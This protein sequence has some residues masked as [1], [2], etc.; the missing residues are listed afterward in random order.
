MM[1]AIPS[2]GTLRP[3]PPVGTRGG[4]GWMRGPCACPGWGGLA[5]HILE[6]D[7]ITAR[8]GQAQGPHPSPQPPIVPTGRCRAITLVVHQNSS[9][10]TMPL[11]YSVGKNH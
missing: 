10:R 4:V 8:G 1:V 9:G 2:V 11:P 6:P 3:R 7:G 5:L